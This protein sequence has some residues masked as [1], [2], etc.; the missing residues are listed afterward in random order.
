M[1]QDIFAQH[2]VISA[3]TLGL[4]KEDI[5]RMVREAEDYKKED[6]ARR[7]RI[8]AKDALESYAFN[9]KST[10]EDGKLKSILDKCNEVITW[11]DSNQV[12]CI[13]LLLECLARAVG[14]EVGTVSDELQTVTRRGR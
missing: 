8:Q 12:S 2:D 1:L 13:Q 5:E 9:M 4:S 11:M 14:L 3:L 6:D 10:V 7:E